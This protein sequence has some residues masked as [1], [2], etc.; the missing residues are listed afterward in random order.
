MKTKPTKLT[1]GVGDA[2]PQPGYQLPAVASFSGGPGGCLLYR[3][4]ILAVVHDTDRLFVAAPCCPAPEGCVHDFNEDRPMGPV[5]S[6][7]G[8]FGVCSCF[9]VVFSLA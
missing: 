9:A 2:L 7:F 4:E 8:F 5:M 3:P 1:L 6:D